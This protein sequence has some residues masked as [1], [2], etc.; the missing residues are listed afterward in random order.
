M[1]NTRTVTVAQRRKKTTK[2]RIEG[3]ENGF[4]LVV[5]ALVVVAVGAWI[6]NRKKNDIVGKK[7]NK[8]TNTNNKAFNVNNAPPGKKKQGGGGSNNNLP[9]NK[10]QSN[11]KSKARREENK[12]KREEKER[13]LKRDLENAKKAGT[14]TKGNQVPKGSDMMGGEAGKTFTTT[15]H[16]KVP[17]WYAEHRERTGKKDM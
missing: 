1:A 14:T 10:R 12:A 6:V 16:V 5:V 15:S 7:K 9:R 11:K 2:N 13:Q 8:N 4:A 17:V 3:N